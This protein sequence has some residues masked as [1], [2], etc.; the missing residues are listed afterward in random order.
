MTE[1]ASCSPRLCFAPGTTGSFPRYASKS[2]LHSVVSEMTPKRLLCTVVVNLP[3]DAENVRHWPFLKVSPS[4]YASNCFRDG[5]SAP[6]AG[7][8]LS[9][10]ASRIFA[11]SM[12]DTQGP[13][14]TFFW[15]FLF[16]RMGGNPREY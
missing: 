6:S 8:S 7:R 1:P 3:P 10:R 12:S 2:A 11:L 9:D 14:A 4:K 13:A 15:F 16:S 5:E